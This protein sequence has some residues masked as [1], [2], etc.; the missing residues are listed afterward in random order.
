MF[1]HSVWLNI[2]YFRIRGPLSAA[3][4]IHKIKFNSGDGQAEREDRRRAQKRGV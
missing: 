4:G 3:N 2:V 1:C